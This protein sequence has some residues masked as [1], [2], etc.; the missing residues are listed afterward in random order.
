M[1]KKYYDGTK[2]LS[3]RDIDGNKPEIYICTTNRTGGKTTYFNRLVFNRFFN[4][5]E[6][7]CF[8]YRY[9]YELDNLPD[10]IFKDIKQLFFKEKNLRA[11][12]VGKNAYCKLF[13][14]NDC[15]EEEKNPGIPCGYAIALNSADQIK[16]YSHMFSDVKRIVFDEFQSETNHYCSNEIEKFY[17]IH[18]S[19]ARGDGQQVRYVPV[20]MIS[21]PVSLL[22]PYYTTMG[23]A[24]RLSPETKFLRGK[25]FV[26]EQGYV[27]SAAKA[28]EESAFVKAMSNSKYSA[29]SIKGNYLN[30]N[31]A[32]IEKMTGHSRYVVT[33]K[34]NDSQFA[35]REFVDSG[36]MYCDNNIDETCKNKIAVTTDDHAINYVMLNHYAPFVYMM[37]RLFNLGCFRFKNL[38][39]KEAIFALLS[40]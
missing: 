26:L 2:L 14:Y 21:N 40:Y 25:G 17:S 39:C 4:Y 27:D 35:I 9:S 8:L 5:G 20:Y 31:S 36:I 15:D 24:A 32:F 37:R 1:D 30:D 23:I 7:M 16:R 33:I 6:K 3:L 22:N 28:Q 34:Y 38:Q 11:E 18:T 29:Y 10:K 19:I 13:V 12:R